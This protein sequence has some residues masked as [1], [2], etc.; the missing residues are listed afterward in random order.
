MVATI[1]P[2]H[3]YEKVVFDPWNLEA[4]DADDTI[5]QTNPPADPNVGDFFQRLPAADYAPTWYAQRSGGA[6]GPL[7]EAAATQAA[8]TAAS[9]PT[10]KYFDPLGR[11]FLSVADNGATGKYL[12]HIALDIQGNTRSET[13]PHNREVAAY[14]YTILGQRIHQA[15]MEAG[16]RWTLSDVTGKEIRSWDS[17][18][19]NFRITYDALRRPLGHY[20]LGTDPANSDPRTLAAEILYE[21]IDYGEGQVNDQLLNLRTRI[22]QHHD[23]AGVVNNVITDPATAQQIGYDFKGNPLGSS[24]QF[25]QDEQSLPNW[26]QA[27][28]VFLVDIYVSWT[29]YDALNRVTAMSAPD[30]SVLRPTYN[31]AN[32]LATLNANLQGAAATTSFINNI[33][34]NPKRQRVLIEYSNNVTTT[35]SYDL[36]TFRLINLT[37]TRPGFPG[38]QQTVQNLSYTYD[39]VGNITHIQDDADIQ[40]V[41]FFR[42]RRV[43]PSA[44]FS[45]DAIYRLI[46]ATG[47][48]QL[49]LVGGTLLPPAPT[50][51]NDVPRVGLVQP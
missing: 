26:F 5:L 42:N 41:I 39:P 6:L 4:W 11:T 30:G 48:E 22:F 35:Y 18:G 25:A 46:Q 2:N 45:Y 13:D 51:Y 3:T 16:Q 47:R 43:E 12:S 7:E 34:Y 40:N 21:T 31:Q 23:T 20:V 24:R 38:N 19:H 36:L 17:R 14:D 28:P 1:Y 33:D 8:T 44:D 32:L 9:T 29:Q 15:S 10:V 37:T 27:P 50:S 49:G